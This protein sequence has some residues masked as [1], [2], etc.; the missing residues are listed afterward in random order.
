M[1]TWWAPLMV[2]RPLSH[3]VCE[4]QLGSCRRAGPCW[5]MTHDWKLISKPLCEGVMFLIWRMTALVEPLILRYVLILPFMLSCSSKLLLDG[6]DNCKYNVEEFISPA[7]PLMLLPLQSP[8]SSHSLLASLHCWDARLHN[9]R[10]TCWTILLTAILACAL[11]R[12]WPVHFVSDVL[13][14]GLSSAM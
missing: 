9:Q 5:M 4:K 1:R 12:D 14:Q 11:A 8:F 10:K 7:L 3:I 2:R 6:P 13:R